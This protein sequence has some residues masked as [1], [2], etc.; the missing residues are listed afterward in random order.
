MITS[1]YNREHKT[2]SVLI[3]WKNLDIFFKLWNP[4]TNICLPLEDLEE[5]KKTNRTFIFNLRRSL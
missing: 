5:E 3:Q 1:D 4:K 2:K